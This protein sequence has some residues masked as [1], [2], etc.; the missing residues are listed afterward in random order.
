MPTS[1][2]VIEAMMGPTYFQATATL[3]I[4]VWRCLHASPFAFNW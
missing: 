2:A 4:T 3:T 1:M